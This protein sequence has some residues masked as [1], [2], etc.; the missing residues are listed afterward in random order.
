MTKRNIEGNNIDG[1]KSKKIQSFDDFDEDFEEFEFEQTPDYEFLKNLYNFLNKKS[2]PKK[3]TRKFL[4][5][6]YDFVDKD[7]ISQ[8][9]LDKFIKT[10]DIDKDIVKE[11][12]TKLKKGPRTKTSRDY[13]D[14]LCG[15]GYRYVKSPC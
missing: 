9:S 7:E 5:H 1:T 2:Y 15:G 13:G 6:A 12:K 11:I 10:E 14:D 3:C 8:D 4:R